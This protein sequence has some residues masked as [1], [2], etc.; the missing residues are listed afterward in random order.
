MEKYGVQ[1]DDHKAGLL[2]EESEIMQELAKLV[3]PIP[4]GVKTASEAHKKRSELEQRL[5]GV[6]NKI[7]SLDKPEAAY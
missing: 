5:Q 3:G 1:L 4:Q 7:H 2:Q 6:K